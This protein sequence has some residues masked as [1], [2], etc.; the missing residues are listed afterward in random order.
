MKILI[1]DTNRHA[2]LA[3]GYGHIA[4]DL[5]IGLDRRGHD[6]YFDVAIMTGEGTLDNISRKHFDDSPDTI[7]LW[8][9]PPSFIKDV[10]FDPTKRNV[11]FTMH[12]TPTFLGHK[13]EWPEL[14]NKCKLV[15]TPTTW[16]KDVF[17]KNGV[18]VPIEVIPLGVDLRTFHPSA[19]T[20]YFKLLTVHEA[21]GAPSSR[22]DWRMT[23]EAFNEQ[24]KDRN[25]AYLTVKTWSEK[26]ENIAELRRSGLM[27]KVSVVTITLEPKSLVD[28]YHSHN[29]FI[30]NSNKEGWSFPLTEAIACG[31]KVIAF[32]NPVLRENARSYPVAWFKKK[33]QLQYHMEAA[34]KEWRDSTKY[35]HE[36]NWESS[37]TK[38]EEVLKTL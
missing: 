18:T 3:S 24:F 12:E 7:W 36:Y 15:L 38:L 17:E 22:E 13:A 26:P 14:L 34:Y 2:N 30:K 32:D 16:N 25:N 31:T 4:R 11:F 37:I 21:F 23:L 1:L 8:T 35:I 9:K 10:K 5:A 20:S 29:V 28:I 19:V 6:V 27:E 33:E